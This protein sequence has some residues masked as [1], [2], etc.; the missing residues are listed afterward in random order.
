MISRLMD[1]SVTE[2]AVQLAGPNQHS[3]AGAN[4]RCNIIPCFMQAI[5]E[6][7]NCPRLALVSA[8]RNTLRICTLVGNFPLLKLSIVFNTKGL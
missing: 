5:C 3:K 4:Y 1:G 8:N 2:L 7:Y 6:L